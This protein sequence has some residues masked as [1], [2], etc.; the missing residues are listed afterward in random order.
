MNNIYDEMTKQAQ[1][2][3]SDEGNWLVGVT[4]IVA[5]NADPDKQHR[6]KVVIPTIDE[7]VVY[8]EWARQM[9]FCLGNGYGSAFVPPKGS[10]VVLFGQLGQKF[11]LFYASLYNEEMLM[12]A[13]LEDENNVG[14]KVPGN[15]S[16]LAVLLAKIEAQNIHLIAS[17][18]AKMTGENTEV[19]AQQLSKTTGQSVD[20]I[21]SGTNRLI[22][23]TVQINGDG[24][25]T[26]TGG[27]VSINGS[28]VTIRGRQVLASGPPI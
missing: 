28:N 9:I 24:S 20:S 19:I 6:V 25:I 21:A 2:A 1:Q 23:Q 13:G 12:P 5:D 4:G 11:N 3:F 14:I 7:D 22:G 15:L 26:I 27:N 10:E 16:F 17:Q 8:D 18:L